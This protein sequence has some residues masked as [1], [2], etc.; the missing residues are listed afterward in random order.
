MAGP[1]TSGT[2]RPRRELAAVLVA[3]AAGAGLVL[4]ASRQHLA[5]VVERP[6]RPLPATVTAV[7]AQDLRPAVTA[8]AVAAL[9]SLAAVLATRGF[10]R[11][12]TGLLTAALGAATALLGA[13]TVTPAAVLAAAGRARGSPAGSSASAGSV[14]A[15]SGQPTAPGSLGGFPARVLFDGSAWRVLMIAGAMLVITAGIVV[16]ARAGRLPAMS[17]RYDRP[18]LPAAGQ[19]GAARAGGMDADSAISSGR[20]AGRPGGE[21]MWESLSA[22]GD[23]TAWPE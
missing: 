16:V 9:A 18:P 11:R 12:L 20:D 13:G 14:T 17:G 10:L 7:S 6:P 1:S 2:S 15:G 23:P 22:G 19:A 5:R 3:G 21:S 4:L 8:L